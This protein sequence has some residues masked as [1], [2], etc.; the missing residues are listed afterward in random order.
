MYE[1]FEASERISTTYDWV[2]LLFTINL[3]LIAVLKFNFDERFTKLFSLMY[4]EKY[5]TDY[6]KSRPLIFNGFHFI[7]FFII[8][9]NISFL[10]YFS[11]DEFSS[12]EIDDHLIFYLKILLL[13]F[14]YL[15]LRYVCGFL[16]AKIFDLEEEQNYATFLKFSNLSLISSQLYFPLLIL[17]F[18]SA[19]FYS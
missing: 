10:L 18:Y 12:V 2:T 15:V 13:T 1:M 8:V 7:F 11:F 17:S 16:L 5:Y 19:G 9:F 6:I 3:V 4:S 14:F